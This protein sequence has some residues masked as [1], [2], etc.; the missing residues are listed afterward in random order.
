M[1]R[2]FAVLLLILPVA[3]L[4][5]DPNP[6]LI[7]TTTAPATTRI[8]DTVAWGQR[9]A[10]NLQARLA[11][12]NTPAKGGTISAVVELRNTGDTAVPAKGIHIWFMVAQGK[13][14]AYFTAAQKSSDLQM[15]EAGAFTTM[16]L[17]PS[18]LPAYSYDPSLQLKD[19]MP[20]AGPDA[21]APKSLGNLAELLPTGRV[22]MKAFVIYTSTVDHKPYTDVIPSNTFDV[23]VSEGDFAKLDETAKKSL[24]SDTLKLFHGDAV[25]GKAGHDKSLKIGEP[26]LQPLLD[27][28]SDEHLSEAG[29]LWLVATLVDLGDKRAVPALIKQVE[30]GGA[31]AYVIAYHGPRM[32]NADLNDAIAKAASSSDD[33]KLIAWS[34]RGLGKA[35]KKLDAKAL[36]TMVGQSDGAGRLEAVDILL[37]QT[38]KSTVQL[39]AMLITDRETS[40]QLRAIQQ[41]AAAGRKIF[42]EPDL[43]GGKVAKQLGQQRAAIGQ[44]RFLQIEAAVKRNI[45]D[46]ILNLVGLS[47][48]KRVLQGA[49]IGRPVGAGHNNLPVQPGRRQMQLADRR[50]QRVQL[51][52]PVVSVAGE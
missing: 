35:G 45:E 38:D 9:A 34:A 31:K 23:S 32:K 14:K 8:A 21:P 37:E 33:P 36:A 41:V 27:A 19:G 30:A 11:I 20:N 44:A 49:E 25:A 52:G 24:I 43:A 4:A 3:A 39:L 1:H 46:K 51:G 6:D 50:R 18:S 16:L 29:Q 40:V 28:L 17:D 10:N 5:A 42:A 26:I 13:D 2:S 15:L 7:T 12:T 22:R 47:A 48:I